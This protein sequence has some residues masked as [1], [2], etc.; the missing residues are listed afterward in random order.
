MQALV[1]TAGYVKKKQDFT[2]MMTLIYTFMIMECIFKA[3]TQGD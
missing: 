2:A 1:Y 3:W